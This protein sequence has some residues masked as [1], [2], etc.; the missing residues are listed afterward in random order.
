[1]R[2]KI[3]ISF[4]F[5]CLA[6]IN[7]VAQEVWTLKHCINYALEHNINVKQQNNGIEKLRVDGQALRNSYLPDLTVNGS[8]RAD[9]GRSLRVDNTYTDT[10]SQTSFCSIVSEVSLFSGFK[11]TN[12][13]AKN[14]YDIQSSV[15]NLVEIKND[16]AL[17]VTS[18]YF[19][20]LLNKEIVKISKDQLTLI[21][22]QETRTKLLVDNGKV[23]LSQLYDI[24]AQKADDELTIT[25]A[26]NTL[27]LSILDLVQLLELK[28]SVAFNI[29]DV[30]PQVD[31]SPI[32][33]PD[34]VYAAS[35]NCMPQ[36]SRAHS[37]L[38]SNKL[39]IK[40]AKSGYYPTLSF[41]AGISTNYYA[42][43]N[44]NPTF[45]NQLKNNMQ[46]SIYLNLR[47][48]LFDCFVTKKNVRLAQID[49]ENSRM[50]LDKEK[51]E[52]YKKIQKAYLDVVASHDK[53]ASTA[54]AV[55]ANTEAHRYAKERYATGKSPVYEYSEIKL[56]L[57]DALSKQAQA[58]YT[59]L[60]KVKVLDFYS[61]KSLNE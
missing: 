47:V 59:Y 32:F 13:I 9:F 20:I 1:M 55:F 30:Y 41:G 43:G 15:A 24:M 58:K 57:A 39:S 48:P 36:I 2:R 35:L 8:Q 17:N 22:E 28:E 11:T 40:V 52:L 51:K 44:T 49:T 38:E 29:E 6:S 10:N 5:V 34:E 42:G 37:T 4:L 27:K 25:E 54:K 12:M 19:Q 60:L 46:R 16:I 45:F 21:K 33:N 23:P 26:E 56:K 3:V 31:R 18:C 7:I 53:L 61:G 14:K 50:S